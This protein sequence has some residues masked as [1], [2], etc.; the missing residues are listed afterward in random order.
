M[1]NSLNKKISTQI[2]IAIIFSLAILVGGI[3]LWQ[4]SEIEKEEVE[5]P[6]MEFLEKEITEKENIEEIITIEE[7]QE[8]KE[9]PHQY[10]VVEEDGIYYMYD[11][12]FSERFV[13]HD[14]ENFEFI[15]GIYAKDKNNIYARAEIVT[16]ADIKTFVVL[17]DYIAKDQYQAYVGFSSIKKADLTSFQG[18]AERFS[19]DKDY[20]FKCDEIL[21][22]I[23]SSTVEF[24][25][26]NY[27]KDK[28][29]VYFVLDANDGWDKNDFDHNYRKIL[30]A[31]KETFV[32]FSESPYYSYDKNGV[33]HRGGLMEGVDLETFEIVN[34]D[35]AKDKNN[36]YFGYKIVR[37]VDAPT[38]RL[39]ISEYM[40]TGGGSRNWPL[41]DF[42]IDKNNLLSM[43]RT[44]AYPLI[45]N[46]D[47]ETL[48][49]VTPGSYSFYFKDKN[50][51][52]GE[53]LEKN[54][55]IIN[56]CKYCLDSELIMDC[57]FNCVEE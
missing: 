38:F 36:V 53:G 42:Y 40:P 31:D 12:A 9:L 23:D 2:A 18:I 48:E 3:T 15:G 57:L 43:K 11:G 13:S 33:Y 29:G 21:K 49:F 46:V 8:V 17:T 39:F 28:N 27:I 22:G 1:F 25:D 55:V 37:N 20:V 7:T 16:D 47:I 52:Y 41:V 51:L 14:I 6:E 5:L 54:V 32:F 26:T 50:N 44:D 30:G 34:N 35:Y 56:H 24:I 10:R 45:P 19:K 4:Y